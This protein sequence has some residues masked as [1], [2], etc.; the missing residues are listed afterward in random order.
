MKDIDELVDTLYKNHLES[1]AIENNDLELLDRF[2]YSMKTRY[3]GYKEDDP[4]RYQET[5]DY[6]YQAELK[7]WGNLSNDEKYAKF[8]LD[9]PFLDLW[10]L[11]VEISGVAQRKREGMKIGFLEKMWVKDAIKQ[12]RSLRKNILL[13][14]N[15]VRA[16]QLIAQSMTD[17][18]YICSKTKGD[19]PS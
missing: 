14:G 10:D 15:E 19:F 9:S 17:A 5:L 6:F 1:V 7:H 3:S 18:A 11:S 16:D 13:K 4:V 2:R 8:T 12:M